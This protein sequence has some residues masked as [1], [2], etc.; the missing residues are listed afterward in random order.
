MLVSVTCMSSNNNQVF[1]DVVLYMP[2]PMFLFFVFLSQWSDL[3]FH[4]IV[5]L[6]VSVCRIYITEI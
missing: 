1:V 3:L 6:T 4:D 2:M 5:C